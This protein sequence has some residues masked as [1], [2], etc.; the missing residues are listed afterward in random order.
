MCTVMKFVNS[1]GINLPENAHMVEVTFGSTGYSLSHTCDNKLLYTATYDSKSEAERRARTVA[2]GLN[3][4]GETV[5][6]CI[7]SVLKEVS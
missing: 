4:S 2:H 6:L 5:Y 1:C 3:S 7:S